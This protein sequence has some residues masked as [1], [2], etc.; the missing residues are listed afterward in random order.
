[1]TNVYAALERAARERRETN[2]SADFSESVEDGGVARI[3]RRTSSKE[4]ATNDCANSRS[5]N[6]APGPS[7]WSNGGPAP[8]RLTRRRF[9]RRWKLTI[10]FL[11]G[12]IIGV[13]AFRVFESDDITLRIAPRTEV[14]P[15][16]VTPQ[17]SPTAKKEPQEMGEKSAQRET[18]IQAA[19]TEAVP[20]ARTPAPYESEAEVSASLPPRERPATEPVVA[21]SIETPPTITPEVSAAPSQGPL[22]DLEVADLLARGHRLQ[23]EGDVVSARLFFELAAENGSASAATAIGKTYDPMFLKQYMGYSLADPAKA[24]RWYQEAVR[25]GDPEAQKLLDALQ[26]LSESTAERS[27]AAATD[28]Q[29]P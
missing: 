20:A 27:G 15:F 24:I 26:P 9:D 19:V 8:T 25:D 23:N 13:I 16:S 6:A 7:R 4:F 18:A 3:L 14:L 28:Q 11:A 17:A 2:R 5:E 12:T 1:M 21:Q 22:S 29:L 10:A